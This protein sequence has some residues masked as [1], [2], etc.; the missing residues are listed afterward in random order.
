MILASVSPTRLAGPPS[1]TLNLCLEPRTIRAELCG[2]KVL[3][4]DLEVVEEELVPIA[5]YIRCRRRRWMN[6][7]CLS[8]WWRHRDRCGNL[9]IRVGRAVTERLQ[10]GGKQVG[11]V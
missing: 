1:H 9:V 5:A 11:G 10:I 7:R 2:I 8:R 6:R 4:V 3:A